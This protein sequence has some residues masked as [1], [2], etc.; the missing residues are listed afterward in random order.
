MRE[1]YGFVETKLAE[2]TR[3]GDDNE[4]MPGLRRATDAVAPVISPV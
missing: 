1:V 4:N 3:T 2:E